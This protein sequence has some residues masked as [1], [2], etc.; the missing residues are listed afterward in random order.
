MRIKGLAA[1]GLSLFL[2]VC[3]VGPNYR[4]SQATVP[5]QWTAPATGGTRPGV[6]PATDQWWKSFNDRELES[7]ITRAA[8]TN[9][10]VKSGVARLEEA[11]AASRIA[12]SAFYPQ[13]GASVSAERIRQIGVGLVPSP[14]NPAGVR[15]QI[16]LYEITNYQGRFDASWEIDVFGRIRRETEAARANV[17]ASEQDRR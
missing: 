15:P 7:L 2:T 12:K 9:Y 6:E 16:F 13:I 3:A 14:G 10:D 1:I 5:P 17:E 8:E 4:R 11:R